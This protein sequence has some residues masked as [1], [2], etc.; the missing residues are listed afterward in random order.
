M[1]S[2]GSPSRRRTEEIH[3]GLAVALSRF[4]PLVHSATLTNRGS[5]SFSSERHN[6]A[7]VM[8]GCCAIIGALSIH[9]SKSALT[10]HRHGEDV[11]QDYGFIHMR[12]GLELRGCLHDFSLSSLDGEQ[13][14]F[15]SFRC[16]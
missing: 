4:V 10:I 16:P 14:R 8:P 13:Q 3:S 6:L 5:V 11:D 15:G 12:V 2:L 9:A 7:R 1:W